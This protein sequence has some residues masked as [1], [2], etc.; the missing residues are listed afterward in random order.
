MKGIRGLIALS[1]LALAACGDDSIQSPD[2][3]PELDHIEV[4]PAT[5]EVAAGDT[6]QLTATGF[7]TRQPGVEGLDSG[8]ID[9]DW[10]VDDSDIASVDGDGLVTGLSRGQVTVTASQDGESATALITV[11]SPLLLELVFDPTEVEVPVGAEQTVTVL[12]LYAGSEEPRELTDGT[13][14]AWTSA[15]PVRA[16]VD[17]TVGNPTTVTGVS[18]GGTTLTATAT[19]ATEGTEGT[20]V[21]GMVG[22]TVSDAA[23]LSVTMVEP[24]DTTIGVGL[25]QQFTA[26]GEYSDG[27]SAEIPNEQLDWTSDD[28]SIATID[29][30]G[31]ATG[32]GEGTATIT[33]TLKP[34]VSPG[35]G[36]EE[37]SGST[38]LTVTPDQC[39]SRLLQSNGATVRAETGPNLLLCL[40]C[41]VDDEINVIDDDFDNFAKMIIPVGLLQGYTQIT[42]SAAEG[43]EFAAGGV[44]GFIISRPANALL[45]AELI[46][47]LTVTTLLDGEEQ[48]TTNEIMPLRLTLLGLLGDEQ[49]VLVTLPEPAAEPHDALRLRFSSGLLSALATTNV[50]SACATTDIVAEDD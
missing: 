7:F 1:A 2:F 37:R 10:S 47:Q 14:V 42:V 28:D 6:I 20:T 9:A 16:I 40:G 35:I 19:N 50:Y 32:T 8:T 24:E 44:P 22:V 45:S 17:P 39:I 41:L 38:T 5:G 43:T 29:A 26:I 11:T 21:S 15:N 48:Q 27:S 33:V 36:D 13:T 46:S 25:E 23:L 49:Q 4:T 12:G 3:S 31:L 30:E 18:I 34:A